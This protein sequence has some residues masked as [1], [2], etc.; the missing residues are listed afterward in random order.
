MKNAQ[1][2]RPQAQRGSALLG[3]VMFTAVLMLIVASLLNWSITERRLNARNAALLEARNAAEALA[4]FGFSQ[5]RQKFET[6]ST[7]SLNPSGSD[8]LQMPASSF[9]TGGNVLTTV[10]S[11]AGI[12]LIGGTIRNVPASGGLYFVD[13]ADPNNEFDPLRGKWIFRRDVAVISKATVRVPGGS[14]ITSYAMEKISVRGAP[15]FAHAIFYNMDLEIFPGPTMNIYGPVHVNGN[16]YCSSQGNQLNFRGPVTATGHI[17]HAWKNTLSSTQ[18]TGGETLGTTPVRFVNRAG[19]LVDLKTSSGVWKDSTM[20]GSSSGNMTP[21]ND[22]RAYASQTWNGNLQTAAHGIQEYRPVAISQYKEDTTPNDNHEDAINTG[23]RIIEPSA[24]PSTSDAEYASKMEVEK[25]K[26]SND[27]AIYI[28]IQPGTTIGTAPSLAPTATIGGLTVAA[29]T[30][31]SKGDPTK[32]KELTL[33]AGKVVKFAAYTTSGSGSSISVTSGMYDRRR[34]KGTALVSLDM[35]E[36]KTAVAEMA[37]PLASRDST[38]AISGLEPEDWTG[39][40]YVEV[41]GAGECDSSTGLPLTTVANQTSVRIINGTGKAASYGTAN[42][43]LTI[44]TNAPIYIKGNFNADGDVSTSGGVNPANNPETGEVP[45]AI[46]ADAITVLSGNYSEESSARTAS[47]TASTASVEIAAAFLMGLTPTNKNSNA[48]SSGG[49]H[50]FPRFLENWSNK[51]VWIRGSLVS[52]FES[53]IAMEKWSTAYYSP[54]ARNW[55][56][57]DLFRNG[58]YPPGTPRVLSYR[59][60]DFTDLS[61]AKYEEVKASFAWGT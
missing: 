25:Q 56:F 30:A 14:N 16:I 40:V 32:V 34:L 61:P 17:F 31:R 50:N 54:P 43:G 52:L 44:A 39:I 58:V 41:V 7:F 33:P 60:V 47:P 35:A 46:A 38:K 13:P 53:R 48:A 1:P 37:K 19:A 26:Y 29:V 28:R 57:N 5:I 11:S 55:G 59:R 12:E 6:R 18:G 20:G 15:L 4:E 23:R 10:G 22:F 9:W 45:C 36:L 3:V 42:A 2:P 21:S 24:W 8:A 49:V 27:A 51:A